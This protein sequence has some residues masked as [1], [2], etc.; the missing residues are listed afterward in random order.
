MSQTIE[1]ILP[2]LIALPP[3]DRAFIADQLLAS[4]PE[5][6]DPDALHQELDRRYVKHLSGESPGIPAEEA[7]RRLREK[8]P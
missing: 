4:L 7:F 5:D 6:T 8:Y 3:E 1:Q 2:S